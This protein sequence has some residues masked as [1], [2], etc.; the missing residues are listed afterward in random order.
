LPFP[1][2]HGRNGVEKFFHDR[3]FSMKRLPVLVLASMVL[4]AGCTKSPEWSPPN[5]LPPIGTKALFRETVL[6][7]AINAKDILAGGTPEPYLCQITEGTPITSL[8]NN[9]EMGGV[10]VILDENSKEDNNYT[11]RPDPQHPLC[12]KGAVIEMSGLEF[13]RATLYLVAVTVRDQRQREAE[14]EIRE[15][16]KQRQ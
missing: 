14:K 7:S 1:N 13:G 4:L 16:L 12:K 10:H 6:L 8:H 2:R 9:S 5:S 15:V 3:E 11:S